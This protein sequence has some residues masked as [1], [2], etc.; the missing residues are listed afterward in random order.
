MFNFNHFTAVSICAVK[1]GIRP[2]TAVG[3]SVS[4]WTGRNMLRLQPSVLEFAHWN[5]LWTRCFVLLLNWGF[6]LQSL[7]GLINSV[8]TSVLSS[9]AVKSTTQEVSSL[10]EVAI[11]FHRPRP[12]LNQFQNC[13]RNWIVVVAMVRMKFFVHLHLFWRDSYKC[14]VQ[15][16]V[17]DYANNKKTIALHLRSLGGIRA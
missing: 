2:K 16:D 14:G 6:S 4:L 7:S 5:S 13:F 10:P 17:E 15:L 11:S 1:N 9:D 8:S 12:N 3:E